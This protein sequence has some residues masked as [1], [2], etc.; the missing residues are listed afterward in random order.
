MLPKD[1][2]VVDLFTFWWH[3]LEFLVPLRKGPHGRK[4]DHPGLSV[5]GTKWES[6]CH[7]HLSF[8]TGG[9]FVI[10]ILFFCD[11]LCSICPKLQD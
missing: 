5:K 2:C 3:S 4:L 9:D 8:H 10:S 6:A 1:L 11:I 7:L